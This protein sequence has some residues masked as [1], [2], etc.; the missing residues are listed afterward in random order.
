MSAWA[1][2]FA[3]AFVIFYFGAVHLIFTFV[4]K[5]LHPRDTALV[6]AM[7]VVSPVI[8][9]QTTMWRA[10]IGFN[11]SHSY[12]AMLFGLVYGYLARYHPEL[13]LQDVFLLVLGWVVLI[14][15]VV[16]A[17][18]YWFRIPFVGISLAALLY[19]IALI[20]HF[21]EA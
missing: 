17:K 13:L 21:M 16:L 9:N 7:H 10:W 15:Y 14:A 18:L 20:L 1:L 3:S 11:A 6:N 4:G 12:G 5:R 19:S 2:I 8:S